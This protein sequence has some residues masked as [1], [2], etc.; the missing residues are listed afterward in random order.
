MH[1]TW[2]EKVL[3]FCFKRLLRDVVQGEIHSNAFIDI[4]YAY[5]QT[6]TLAV[7][8]DSTISTSCDARIKISFLIS[9]SASFEKGNPTC[10]TT[11]REAF[12]DSVVLKSFQEHRTITTLAR[13]THTIAPTTSPLTYCLSI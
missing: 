3:I 7:G 11:A 13:T 6:I 4:R 12:R 10:I 5:I 9:S 8:N 2:M 1:T